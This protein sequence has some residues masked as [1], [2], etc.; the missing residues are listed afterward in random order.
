MA[1]AHPTD[2]KGV[3]GIY[4]DARLVHT[5]SDGRDAALFAARSL[6]DFGRWGA[7]EDRPRTARA[8]GLG[9]G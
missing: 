6:R 3:S 1:A 9:L 5:I 7:P 8:T 2:D 4:P